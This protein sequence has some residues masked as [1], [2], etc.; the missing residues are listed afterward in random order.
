MAVVPIPDT[1]WRGNR[2][3]RLTGGWHTNPTQDT[4]CAVYENVEML[5]DQ[6]VRCRKG[7]SRVNRT[8]LGTGQ[9]I[10]LGNQTLPTSTGSTNY[11]IVA[12]EGTT[13]YWSDPTTAQMRAGTADFSSF[14]VPEIKDTDSEDRVQFIGAGSDGTGPDRIFMAH[15]KWAH[16]VAWAGSGEAVATYVSASPQCRYVAA[17]N[18]RIYASDLDGST[19][20]FS[21]TG[22]AYTWPSESNIVVSSNYGDIRG[23][24]TVENRLF[25]FCARGILYMEGDPEDNFFVG[26]AHPDIGLDGRAGQYGNTVMFRNRGNFYQFSGTGGV[27]LASDAIRGALRDSRYSVVT[28]PFHMFAYRSAQSLTDP[29]QYARIYV[30][31]RVRFGQWIQWVYPPSTSLG[32]AVTAHSRMTSRGNGVVVN[33][34]DGNVYYQEIWDGDDSTPGVRKPQDHPGVPVRAR[35]HT[36]RSDL[37]DALAHK[38][39]RRLSVYGSGERVRIALLLSDNRGTDTEVVM[40]AP[41]EEVSLPAQ[42]TTPP[43]D[44]SATAAPTGFHYV[45]VRVEGDYLMLQDMTLDYRPLRYTLQDFA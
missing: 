22:D 26:V 12:K 37:A 40:A 11:L 9:V 44:G 1:S 19:I 18:N 34:G 25:I 23:L 43:N 15:P 39:W 3:P 10:G 14:T 38:Q 33:G 21:D 41:A 45:Q 32:G 27:T 13:F 16:I 28:G 5:R 35:V 20:W 17:L 42:F 36:R 30:Y 24:V 7:S 6:Y 29:E 2:F 8:S 31:D 4:D